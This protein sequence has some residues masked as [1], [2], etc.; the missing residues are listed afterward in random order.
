MVNTNYV[1]TYDWV[2]SFCR[3]KCVYVVVFVPFKL[4]SSKHGCHVLRMVDFGS[5][6]GGCG[7]Q[8]GIFTSGVLE[9]LLVEGVRLPILPILDSYGMSRTT[10]Q[11]VCNG[12]FT[13]WE[14]QIILPLI[15]LIVD[16]NRIVAHPVRRGE[17]SSLY[18]KLDSQHDP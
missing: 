10:E 16:I 11:N 3:F 18:P 5:V 14:W 17:T 4:F 13:L 15:Y 2:I 8:K 9:L 6:L 12:R 7:K 1:N